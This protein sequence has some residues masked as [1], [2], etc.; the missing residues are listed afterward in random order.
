MSSPR[1]LPGRSRDRGR[2]DRRRPDEPQLPGRRRRRAALRAD[3][4]PGH[5]PAR[6]RP[7]QRAPQHAGGGRRG[8]R[9]ASPRAP[10]PWNVMVLE[11]L[12]GRTM[13]NAAFADP[14]QPGADRR[15]APPAPRR[16]SLPLDFDMFRLTERYLRVVP[17]G[18]CRIPTATASAPGRRP[19]RGGPR[20]SA[21]PE[22]ALPQRPAGRELPRRRR[23]AVHRRLRVQRQQRPDLR[24]RQHVPGA[25]LGR[26]PGVELCA[27]YFGEAT[28]ALLA[29]MR[30]HMIMS[31]VG[32]TLWA[33]IQAR[34][35]HDRLRLLGLG[36]GA[37]GPGRGQPGPPDLE[38]WLAD[39]KAGLRVSR[40]SGS[41]SGRPGR[42]E[43]RYRTRGRRRR[44][45]RAPFLRRPRAAGRPCRP[46]ASTVG[47]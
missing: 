40:A 45:P 33:A 28:P 1:S 8:R 6:D 18:R 2:A 9:A 36:R 23:A 44:R 32:W 24:A 29:R 19:N 14:R 42:R 22:R 26:G 46:S 11:W 41:R 12:P 34:I 21:A 31:D 37:L 7:C 43:R 17:S 39:V 30:L 20:R 27:A 3:P 13:S 35:S 16:P 47:P 38:A 5:R 10:P 15:G 4:R 25:R